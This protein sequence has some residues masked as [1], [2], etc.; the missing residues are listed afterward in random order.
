MEIFEKS[1]KSQEYYKVFQ[2]ENFKLFL[3]K[4]VAIKHQKLYNRPPTLKD[5]ILNST[6][7]RKQI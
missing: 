7:V 4:K 5:S 1:I 2:K 3:L 6:S